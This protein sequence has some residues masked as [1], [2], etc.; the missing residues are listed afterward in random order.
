MKEQ[1]YFYHFIQPISKE[2]AYVA[3]EL[4]NSIY[5][6]PRTMLTHSRI[7]IETIVHKVISQEKLKNHMTQNLKENIDLLQVNDLLPEK[8]IDCILNTSHSQRDIT[9]SLMKSSA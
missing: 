8:V 7:F 1:T 6:S 2:L 4:E 9:R 3:R 5:T